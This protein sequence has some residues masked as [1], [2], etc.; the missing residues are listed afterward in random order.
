MWNLYEAYPSLRLG[1][2]YVQPYSSWI[3]VLRWSQQVNFTSRPLHLHSKWRR[4]PWNGRLDGNH[5]RSGLLGKENPWHLW[6]FEPRHLGR[7]TRKSTHCSQYTTAPHVLQQIWEINPY[8]YIL[9]P[10]VTMFELWGNHSAGVQNALPPQLH[11]PSWQQHLYHYYT[12]LRTPTHTHTHT[13]THTIN[14]T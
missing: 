2:I 6:G 5:S 9:S 14:F 3:A 1:N 4:S 10:G 12:K 11:T 7:P 8:Q 13:H